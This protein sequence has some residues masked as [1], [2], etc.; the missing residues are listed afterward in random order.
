MRIRFE[1]LHADTCLPDYWSGHHLPHVQVQ[2]WHGMSIK[3]VKQAI[4]NELYHGYV[5]GSTEEAVLLAA[6]FTLLVDAEK[7]IRALTKAAYAA[8]RRM[9]PAKKGRRKFFTDLE[10]EVR[11]D[12]EPVFAFFVFVE[13]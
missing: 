1:C 9:K 6:D 12:D 8:V 11:E 3:E 10:K 7:R 2:V 13:I 4:L 5:M